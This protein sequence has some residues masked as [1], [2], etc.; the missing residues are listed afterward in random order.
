M[1]IFEKACAGAS[2]TAAP[3]LRRAVLA[4][5]DKEFDRVDEFCENVL[6][7]EPENAAAYLGKMLAEFSLSSAEE[8]VN[9]KADTIIIN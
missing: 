6:N 2:E 9:F 5:E 4:L 3:I 8:L 7:I 1:G